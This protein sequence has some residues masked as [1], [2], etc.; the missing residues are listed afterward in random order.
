MPRVCAALLIP[1]ALLFAQAVIEFLKTVDITE[2]KHLKD[3][4]FENFNFLMAPNVGFSAGRQVRSFALLLPICFMT[5]ASG[6]HQS[7]LESL[8]GCQQSQIK[9]HAG[10]G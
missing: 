1:C 8:Q 9:R 4:K 3:V 5:C 7:G 10:C 6:L 2:T